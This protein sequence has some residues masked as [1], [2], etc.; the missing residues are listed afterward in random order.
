M[1]KKICCPIFFVATSIT[2]IEN[3]FIFEL[4]KKKIW[5]NLQRIIEFFVTQKI[6]IKLSKI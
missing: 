5:A 4:V 6:V 2:K 3:Y 1:K